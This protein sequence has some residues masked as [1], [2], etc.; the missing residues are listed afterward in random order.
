MLCCIKVAEDFVS[1]EGVSRCAAVA[2][3]FR[4]LT[5]QHSN[6]EDK[7]QVNKIFRAKIAAGNF[8]F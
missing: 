5:K 6:H 2:G 1:P 4:N 7:L 8:L 3:E